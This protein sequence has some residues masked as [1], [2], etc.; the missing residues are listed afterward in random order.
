MSKDSSKFAERFGPW[1]VITGGSEG[2]GAEFARQ[3]ASRGLSLVLVARREEVL[4][5][6]CDELREKF[7]VDVLSM[8][9]DLAAAGAVELLCERTADLDVGLLVCSAASA[10]LGDFLD[11][12]AADHTRL[13]DLNCRV[14]ALIT[15]ELGRRM[16]ARGRGGII[17]L[18]SMAGFQGTGFVAHYAASKAYVRVLAEGLW[19]ELRSRGVDVLASCPGLVRTPTL[20]DGHPVRPP[21]L[22]SPLMNCTPVVR[23]T[24]VAL[25]RRPVVVPG[26]ANRLSCWISRRLMPQRAATALASRGTRAMYP[27]HREGITRTTSSP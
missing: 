12:K 11:L 19:H 15:W 22:A 13:L 3:I 20:L 21:W 16:A 18:S 6:F 17:L 4:R 24:L 26:A 10:P 9:L 2:I 8:S 7:R 14:P 25:G 1:A 27:K 23:Q 5:K